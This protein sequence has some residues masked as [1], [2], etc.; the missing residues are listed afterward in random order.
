[1]DGY[2]NCGFYQEVFLGKDLGGFDEDVELWWSWRKLMVIFFKVDVNI[3]WKI[4][5]KEMQCWI[6]EKM[7]EYFQEVMEESKIYF[8]VV[9]FDGDGYVFWDE[10]KVKFL[11]SKGYS[12]KEV[13]DVIRFNEEF[14]VDEEIQEVLENL[15][16]CWYQV[17]SFFVDLLLMEEEF[18]LFFYFEYSWGM[19]RFMVKEIVWDLDQD[20]DKQFF[21]F[22]FIFLFVGIV[23]NQQGQDIDDNWVKDRK[24]EFEEFIDFNYDGIVIVEELESYM[25]FMNE[26]N[27]LNEVK[28]MIVVV[29]ENQNYYLEFEEVFKYSEFFMGSKLVDYVCSVY[30]EF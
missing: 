26:Y 17:D 9:D 25:D 14:K 13:V 22:E 19:F 30:E 23:E 12:E 29:D 27:V 1:M 11:V 2:F 4:S 20:G 16:D 3:D 15:K 7:V 28:Q 8:C 24:K 5:V 18:L 6:M 21:V 10:Y